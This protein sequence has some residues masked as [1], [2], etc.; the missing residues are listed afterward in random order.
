M[1]QPSPKKF[2]N[3]EL[4]RKLAVI[5]G[6]VMVNIGAYILFDKFTAPEL[7]FDTAFKTGSACILLGII[8]LIF[9]RGLRR[10]S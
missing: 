2:P 8:G 10:R 4:K 6:I 9:A 1:N 3:P 7:V 5:Y